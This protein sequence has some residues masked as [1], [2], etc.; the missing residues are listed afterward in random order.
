MRPIPLGSRPL[1]G[2]GVGVT[3]AIPPPIGSVATGVGT[4][5]VVVV[6][7]VVVVVSRFWQPSNSAAVPAIRKPARV[8]VL[9]IAL[10]S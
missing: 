7:V 9:F 4:S 8:S 10:S 6:S 1:Y 2:T 3:S 5:L